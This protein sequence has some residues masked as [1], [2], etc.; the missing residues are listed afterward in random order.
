MIRQ[1]AIKLDA[2]KRFIYLEVP[3]EVRRTL[4]AIGKEIA[5]ESGGVAD[6]AD[7]VTLCFVPK[8]DAPLSKVEVDAV[9]GRLAHAMRDLDVFDVWI[10]GIAYFDTAE[11]D[12]EPVTAVVALVDGPDLTALHEIV[13]DELQAFGWDWDPKHLYVGHCTV[14]YLP[15]G[16]RATY[17]PQIEAAWTVDAIALA[18]ARVHRILLGGVMGAST[19]SLRKK[20]EADLKEIDARANER[21]R[22]LI[23]WAVKETRSLRK[24]ATLDGVGLLS[25]RTYPDSGH[26]LLYKICVDCSHRVKAPSPA[27][28]GCAVGDDPGVKQTSENI[29]LKKSTEE[30]EKCP[31]YDPAP[32]VKDS[33][34]SL[35]DDQVVVQAA[36]RKFALD[37]G[38]ERFFI[39]HSE[40]DACEICAP[41]DGVVFGMSDPLPHGQPS[42]VHARCK[43]TGEPVGWATAMLL[44]QARAEAEAGLVKDVPSEDLGVWTTDEDEEGSARR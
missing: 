11:K 12:G 25:F 44:R 38:E 42:A 29:A 37:E 43:C 27:Q 5:E 15:Q 28:F 1:A 19:A 31:M 17:L 36:I 2:N 7:H 18:N 35:A 30:T 3:I 6:D 26:G 10:G 8:A 33:D 16:G 20:F 32:A 34:D 39:W 22:P 41:L 23:D 24:K 40:P 9:V 14:A 13:R 21:H 4:A